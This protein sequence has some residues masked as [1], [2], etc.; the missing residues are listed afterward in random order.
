M[1]RAAFLK[2]MALAAVASGFIDIEKLLPGPELA[3]RPRIEDVWDIDFATKEIRHTGTPDGQH[4]T[5]R[6]FYSYLQDLFD[7][8]HVMH[9]EI[10][11]AHTNDPR[12]VHT[13][14]IN[15]YSV[16]PEDMEVLT[17]GS[18]TQERNGRKEVY[19]TSIAIDDIVLNLED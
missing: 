15:G 6:E 2:R 4:F 19:A 5:M 8:P 3:A 9:H 17:A 14:M 7:E 1:K 10:P 18:L 16:P 13:Q 11:I 12:L